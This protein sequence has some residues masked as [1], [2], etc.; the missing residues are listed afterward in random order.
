VRTLLSTTRELVEVPSVS[1]AEGALAADIERRLGAVSS[2]E[3]ERIA[4]NVVARSTYGRSK[5]LV[6]GGHL[7]TV[8]PFSDAA[9]KVD[10]D[11]LWGLGAVDM[12]GGLAV[13]LDLA[14]RIEEIPVDVTLVFYVCE[15][16]ERSA[17]GLLGLSRERPELLRADAAV[18]LE[19]TGGRIEAGCQGTMR[20]VVTIG[21]RRAHTA[22][23]YAGLNAIHRLG[24]LLRLVSGYEPRVV[25][26]EGCTYTEQLQA[27][28][29]DGGV[30]ANVVPDVASVTLN[31]RIAPDR[32]VEDAEDWL[33]SFMA[34]VLDPSLG[35]HLEIVDA[36]PGA[37]PALSDPILA[38]LVEAA[39]D[40]PRAKL[41]WTDVSTF[42][43]L[44]V[45]AVNFGPGD[46][47]LAHTADEHV[48][49]DELT[50]ARDVLE[51]FLVTVPATATED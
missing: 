46:P 27:V 14:E 29:V 37:P 9:P 2:L 49:E 4:D 45:P 1:R 43:E 20:A 12:K 13:M 48:S 31:H 51:R 5:R 35:D 44:G 28:A 10:G 7:D 8:P 15:E 19:P 6:L 41:G 47:L 18:L 11:T 16:V 3:V 22:R 33:R 42:F 34:P 24:E 40:E 17:N 30:A 50:K 32:G 23:P 25:E 21:G 39:E 26:L 36:A 38:G